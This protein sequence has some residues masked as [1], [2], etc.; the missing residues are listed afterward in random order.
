MD[1]GLSQTTGWKIDFEQL[2]KAAQRVRELERA[3][4]KEVSETY[5]RAVARGSEE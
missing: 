5:D 4:T 2:K 3:A 1:N